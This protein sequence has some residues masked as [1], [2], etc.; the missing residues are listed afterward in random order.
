MGWDRFDEHDGR[1]GLQNPVQID[2]DELRRQTARALQIVVGGKGYWIPKSQVVPGTLKVKTQRFSRGGSLEIPEW[3]AI[4][5]GL[6]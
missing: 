4:E 2:F 6:A 3:L 5:K 1:Q